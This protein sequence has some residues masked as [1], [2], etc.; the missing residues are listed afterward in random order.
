MSVRLSSCS[1]KSSFFFVN[2]MRTAQLTFLLF[3][4]RGRDQLLYFWTPFTKV[5]KTTGLPFEVRTSLSRTT[6]SALKPFFSCP[7]KD[8]VWRVV[9]LDPNEAKRYKW[10]DPVLKENYPKWI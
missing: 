7:K 4:Q 3:L 8:S 10:M 6:K 5:R 1:L 2:G 9:G